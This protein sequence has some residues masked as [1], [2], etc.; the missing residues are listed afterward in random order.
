MPVLASVAVGL[1]LFA[2]PVA[3]APIGPVTSPAVGAQ[4]AP[5]AFDPAATPQ[6]NR[7]TI[8]VTAQAAGTL[9]VDVLTAGGIVV[10]PLLAPTPVAAGQVQTLEWDGAGV[11]DGHYAVRA[12][13]TDA[14]GV[15]QDA[16]TPVTRDGADPVVEASAPTP[17]VTGRGPVRIRAT[18]EDLSGAT[19]MR[20][21]VESQLGAEIGRVRM[22]APVDNASELS[23]NLRVKGRLLLPG[24]YR[25]RVAADDA[26]G[27]RGTGDAQVLRV[28]RAVPS[29]QIYRLPEAGDKV[30][31]TFDDCLDNG[32]WLQ[33]LAALRR[34][35]V[36]ATF[37]CNGVNVRANPEAA[38]RTVEDG[39]TIGSHTWAHPWMT[40]KGAA[41]QRSQIAG[42]REI[43]WRVARASPA[44][45][46]RPP[47]GDVDQGVRSSAGAEG[48]AWTVLWDV[49]PSDY[50]KPATG[51]L[52]D[53][54]VSKSRPGSI[55]VMHVEA[56]TAA[57]VP[58][59]VRG[60]RARGLEPVSL[61]ELFGTAS[62][63]SR[64]RRG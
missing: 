17:A 15:A 7:A 8:T 22:P 28:E 41:E 5:A 46:F 16:L 37:F 1:T 9:Q 20:L 50:L 52:A 63:L 33:L 55:V 59:M 30:A 26:V 56:N 38:R 29:T 40:R 24:V 10:A 12:R 2:A 18:A 49:D 27:R 19:A 54:V 13:L 31:L 53:R 3:P 25:L 43:W 39:H 62:Y 4:V 60:L 45:F 64:A 36:K 35:R 32:P 21:V 58:L 34:A 61:D 11:P 23:W 14:A 51:V 57:A 42:D 6:A 48:M 47:Y 44:P